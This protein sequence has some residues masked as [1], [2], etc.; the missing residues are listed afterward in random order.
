MRE[1]IASYIAQ[2]VSGAR[3][4]PCMIDAFRKY[5]ELMENMLFHVLDSVGQKKLNG[6]DYF[7][8]KVE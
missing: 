4:R 5:P 3:A 6:V 8:A 7:L 2:S 1:L